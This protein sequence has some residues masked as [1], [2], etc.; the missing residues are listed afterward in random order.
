MNLKTLT[1]AA[2]VVNLVTRM[3]PAS[4]EMLTTKKSPGTATFHEGAASQKKVKLGYLATTQVL[5]HISQHCRTN[6]SNDWFECHLISVVLFSSLVWETAG[7][8]SGTSVGS[9]RQIDITTGVELQPDRRQTAA[10]P[11]PMLY[12]PYCS[13]DGKQ[14]QAVGYKLRVDFRLIHFKSE[15]LQCNAWE[16]E[17]LGWVRLKLPPCILP[18]IPAL[19]LEAGASKSRA[20][21]RTF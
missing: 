16:P 6:L 2:K 12:G 18:C 5:L 8:P 9:W 17:L 20:S 14:L 13:T 4:R 21:T 10:R 3:I 7:L 19:L 15:W 1:R 11:S